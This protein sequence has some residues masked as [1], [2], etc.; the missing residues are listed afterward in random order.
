MA[1][2]KL[3]ESTPTTFYSMPVAGVGDLDP[4]VYRTSLTVERV[5]GEPLSDEQCEEI[6]RVFA[7]LAAA[8]AAPKA[9]A[10]GP[11]PA[12]KAGGKPAGKAGGKPGKKPRK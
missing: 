6:E 2:R 12:S 8:T 1:V 11:R 10:A 4:K 9:P 3:A 7:A 5:D